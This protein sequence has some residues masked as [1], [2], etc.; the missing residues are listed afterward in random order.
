MK[1]DTERCA[2]QKTFMKIDEAFLADD[3][4][5]LRAPGDD[6]AG[7]PN[8][9]LPLTIGASPEYA[10]DRSRL[11]FIRS[12]LE[13]GADPICRSCRIFTLDRSIVLQ[14]ATAW[15]AWTT[16]RAG[17]SDTAPLLHARSQSTRHQ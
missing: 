11:P 8:G 1:S 3:L 12:L 15:I 10:I 14:S 5:A 16:G 9:L 7:L 2:E 17:D 6:P 13:I 4:A